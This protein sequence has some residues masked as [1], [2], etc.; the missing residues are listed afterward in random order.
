[1][2]ETAAEQ[3]RRKG[4]SPSYP[5]VDLSVALARAQEL[6]QAHREHPVNVETVL[7]LWGYGRASGAGLVTL[8]ALKKFGLLLDEGS[9]D[10][11]RARLTDESRA[12]ILDQRPD[13]SERRQRIQRAAL[14][15]TIHRELWDRYQGTLPGDESLLFYLTNER[16]FT[17]N[18]ARE[19]INQFKRTVAFADLQTGDSGNM[20][21]ADADIEDPE[22]EDPS[23]NQQLER[24][25]MSPDAPAAIQFP[26]GSATVTVKMSAPLDNAAWDRMI[27][28]LEAM[29]PESADS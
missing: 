28:L 29:K 14:T 17:E 3:K 27:R 10:A 4:R 18:G 12:I 13:S 20:S 16:N 9:G 15:P 7:K 1:M 21:D 23:D 5:G 22:I 26:V 25:Q 19:F 2:T 24:E 11:R 6:W 8:A